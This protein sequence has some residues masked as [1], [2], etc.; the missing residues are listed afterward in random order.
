MIGRLMKNGTITITRF[1]TMSP[2]KKKDYNQFYNPLQEQL[3]KM[4]DI[5]IPL[6]KKQETPHQASDRPLQELVVDPIY[7]F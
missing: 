4:I 3:Q 5:Q 7:L 6:P 2:N 1:T